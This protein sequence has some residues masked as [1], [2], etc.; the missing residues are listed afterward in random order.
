MNTKLTKFAVATALATCVSLPQYA[1]AEATSVAGATPLS[2]AARVKFQVNVAGVL[3][4]RVG[5]TATTIDQIV[6]NVNDTDVGSGAAVA[7][8][9]GGDVAPGVVT[10]EL[11]SNV[12]AVTITE[13]ND[14]AGAG[15]KNAA[16]DVIPYSEITATSSNNAFVPPAL[17][18]AGGAAVSPATTTGTKITN[19]AEQWTYQFTN[20][21]IYPAGVY[22][23]GAGGFGQVTYTAAIP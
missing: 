11:F 21:A 20:S 16:G 6:F 18:D 22:G 10:A 7:A 8:T 15:L 14:S 2:A 12:G 17:S 1:A 23:D 4:F 13:T 9:S 3:R 19:Y 5:S